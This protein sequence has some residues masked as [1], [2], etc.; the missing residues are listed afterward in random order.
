MKEEQSDF[1]GILFGVVDVLAVVPEAG[2][3]RL[4]A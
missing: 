1:G 4:M 3:D 2:L